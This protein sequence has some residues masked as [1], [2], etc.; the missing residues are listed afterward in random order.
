[1]GVKTEDGKI[2][3]RQLTEEEKKAAEEA[4]ASKGK[5]PPA[6]ESKK[7]AEEEIS[8]EQ[9]AKEEE[10][11]RIKEELEAKRKAEWDALDEDTKFYRTNEDPHKEPRLNFVKINEETKEQVLS[12]Y[13][14]KEAEL[15]VMEEYITQE[16]GC[17]L[18]F[19]KIPKVDEDD[20]K[21]KA[22]KKGQVEVEKIIRGRAWL[23][24]ADFA[25]QGGAET[26]QRVH[27]QTVILEP[28]KVEEEVKKEVKKEIK[29]EVKKEP[30]PKYNSEEVFEP[31]KTYIHLKIT[32][33]NPIV[34]LLPQ[35]GVP[36]PS[37]LIQKKPPLLKYPII[38]K[39]SDMYK[40]QLKIAIE[41]LAKEFL[42]TNSWQKGS[43]LNQQIR[44]SFIDELNRSG[45]YF[46]LKEKLKKAVVRVAKENYGKRLETLRGL[47]KDERD[48]CYSELYRY[49]IDNMHETI[50]ELVDTKRQEL[51]EEIV[52]KKDIAQKEED[53]I[54]NKAN[55]E[56]YITRYKRLFKEY[57]RVGDYRTAENYMLKIINLQER[58]LDTWFKYYKYSMKTG[59]CDKGE[60]CLRESLSIDL[61]NQ[62]LLLALGGLAAS[63]GKLKEAAIYIDQVLLVNV[64][65]VIGNLLRAM[66]CEMQGNSRLASK[67]I[68][69]AKRK[70]MRELE[71]IHPV[72]ALQSSGNIEEDPRPLTEDEYDSIFYNLVDFLLKVKQV[73]LCEKALN[74][75]QNKENPKYL[76]IA[77]QCRFLN[78]DYEGSLRL[79]TALLEREPRN[80][81]ALK[82]KANIHFLR[83][84]YAYAETAYIKYIMTKPPPKSLTI[85][86]NLGISFF[87]RGNWAEA[88]VCFFK[89]CENPLKAT[90]TAWKYLGM[91]Y[92]RLELFND[93]EDALAKANLMD[94]LNAEV[95]GYLGILC[96]K[97]GKRV[98]QANQVLTEAFKL[99]LC[100]ANI[101]EEIVIAYSEAGEHGKAIDTLRRMKETHKENGKYWELMGD[102][103]A[104]M[105]KAK[106][107]IIENYLKALEFSTE[108]NKS[109]ISRKLRILIESDLSLI[110]HYNGILEKLKK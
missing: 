36:K 8:A 97:H 43:T 72:G 61:E 60:E 90:A 46:V 12:S 41:A 109:L 95:W 6:K 67:Y 106:E 23:S 40:L 103:L 102:E 19:D 33:S 30:D 110:E 75:L 10:E 93:A 107:E 7:K 99:N 69:V 49:L 88:K 27:L 96:L 51:H 65:N 104:A 14:L 44:E 66:L 20:K 13:E 53:L 3:P 50:K 71:L 47:T 87:M 63:K 25:K 62:E 21:K 42:K 78:K 29:K 81:R 57:Y 86:M 105:G 58:D 17:W 68:E 54:I 16:Q 98:I 85:Y 52:A 59:N 11:K 45:K 76:L 4:L 38:N 74:Y 32:L 9:K 92:L 15:S 55:Q 34:P 80:Q 18:I 70:K 77:A 89:C 91:S 24:L 73:D 56:D 31:A 1:M 84:E 22:P 28:P 101:L 26:E 48:Q 5:K 100:N 64:S 2:Q 39:A 79:L 83:S 37:D 82:Y 35:E 94:N 108:E